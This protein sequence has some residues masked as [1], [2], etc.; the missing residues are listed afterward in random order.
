MTAP[1]RRK[2]DLRSQLVNDFKERLNKRILEL[3]VDLRSHPDDENE[4]ERKAQNGNAADWQSSSV[5]SD[6]ALYQRTEQALRRLKE[7]RRRIL[8]NHVQVGVCEECGEEISERR[9][10]AVFVTRCI[11]C[12]ERVDRS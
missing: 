11:V 7:L 10:N 4:D 9:L 3:Q 12:Q 2:K 6:R 5:F 8:L 1:A